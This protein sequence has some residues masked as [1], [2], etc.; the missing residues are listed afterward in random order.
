MK[1]AVLFIAAMLGLGLVPNAGADCASGVCHAPVVKQA[2]VVQQQAVVATPVVL[3]QFVP[4]V[5][6]AYSVGYDPT[7]LGIVEELRAIKEE[8]RQGREA[9]T[10]PRNPDAPLVLPQKQQGIEIVPEPM[11]KLPVA[12]D[13]QGVLQ[14]HC[15]ACHTGATAKGG[16]KIFAETGKLGTANPFDLLEAVALGKMPPKNKPRPDAAELTAL[17]N[18]VREALARGK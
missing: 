16:L 18:W 5:V 2:V 6:P 17:R 10:L 8:L 12:P 15:A 7:T 13:W 14:K 3:T 11:G 4:V 9:L 1:Y